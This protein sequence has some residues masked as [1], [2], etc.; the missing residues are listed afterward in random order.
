M[1]KTKGRGWDQG[2]E[3]VVAGVGGVVERHFDFSPRNIMK[4][5]GILY[6]FWELLHTWHYATLKMQSTLVLMGEK[7]DSNLLIF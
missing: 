5:F 6:L 7:I 4:C 3:V 1:D 2:W